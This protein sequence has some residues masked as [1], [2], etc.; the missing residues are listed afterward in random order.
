VPT[1]IC[2]YRFK[3][4]KSQLADNNDPIKTHMSTIMES[5]EAGL[6]V[7]SDELEIPGDNLDLERWFKK[8][9][10]HER[11]IHGHKHA[12]MRIVHEGPTL[13]PA[14]DAHVPREKSFSY[15]ELLPYVEVKVPESQTGSIKRN[16]IMKR[17]SSKKKDQIY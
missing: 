9:K 2:P 3:E 6:F 13:L 14:L 16:R 7:G 4:L 5:F 11:R 1:V 10:G 15:L 12:G 8:P 17:A